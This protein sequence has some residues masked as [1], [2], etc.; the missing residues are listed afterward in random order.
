KII[1]HPISLLLYKSSSLE[2]L[3]YNIH[4][5]YHFKHDTNSSIKA[6]CRLMIIGRKRWVD[7]NISHRSER[8][9]IQDYHWY[10]D[11]QFASH[12]CGRIRKLCLLVHIA[13][14][15]PVMT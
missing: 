4:N 7:G 11:I 1:T 8:Y 2:I 13:V 14:S 5:S 6:I 12:D 15:R 3:K 9:V 10:F